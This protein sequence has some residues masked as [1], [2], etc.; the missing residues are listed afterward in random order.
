[1]GAYGGQGYELHEY[2]YPAE[3]RK[4]SELGATRST[5]TE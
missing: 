1:M 5:H 3:V 4:A 2:R